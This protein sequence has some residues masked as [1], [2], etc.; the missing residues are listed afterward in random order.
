MSTDATA[1]AIT[2]PTLSAVYRGVLPA[3]ADWSAETDDFAITL[4]F[5][6]RSMTTDYRTGIGHRQPMTTLA[7][8]AAKESPRA[9][10]GEITH[11]DAGA[12]AR[13]PKASKSEYRVPS[14]DV[15]TLD[16]REILSCLFL[17]AYAFESTH[18]EWCSELGYDVDSRKGLDLYLR[19][20]QVHAALHALLG[21]AYAALQEAVSDV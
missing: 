5:G 2:Y 8:H 10:A 18:A 12:T 21:S 16:V 3:S 13:D 15:V 20:Q 7:H 19:C 1:A 6:G 17:D 9:V 14:R 4:S 11:V